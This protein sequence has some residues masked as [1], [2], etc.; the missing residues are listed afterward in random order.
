MMSIEVD[1]VKDADFGS[2]YRVW[3]SW[4]LLGTFYQSLDGAWVA[5]PCNC[6]F[7]SGW[8]TAEEAQEFIVRAKAE[9]TKKAKSPAKSRTQQS[10]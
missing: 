9:K 10:I 6:D 7:T 8:N 2:L 1:G 5:Q 4:H 3:D